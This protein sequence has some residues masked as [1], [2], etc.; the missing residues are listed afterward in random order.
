MRLVNSFLQAIVKTIPS[1]QIDRAEG[2][3]IAKA[4]NLATLRGCTQNT[5]GK[6]GY[7]TLKRISV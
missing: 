2:I 4:L 6:S 7:F 5:R 3:A 1:A